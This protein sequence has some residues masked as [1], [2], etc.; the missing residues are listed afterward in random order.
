MTVT[1]IDAMLFALI[2]EVLFTAIF[3]ASSTRPDC[4]VAD[5]SPSTST[6]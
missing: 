4:P 3:G 5:S 1:I 6:Q 2:V